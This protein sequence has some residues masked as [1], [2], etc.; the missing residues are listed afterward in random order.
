MLSLIKLKYEHF[1]ARTL[2]TVHLLKTSQ[3]FTSFSTKGLIKQI[4]ASP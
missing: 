4:K 3:D 1:Q 2:N